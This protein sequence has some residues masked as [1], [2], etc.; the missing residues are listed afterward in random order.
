MPY[1]TCDIQTGLSAAQKADLAEEI[2]RIT[3]EHIGSPI[4]YIHVAVR[5]TPAAHF[6]EGGKLNRVYGEAVANQ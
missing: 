6:V 2:V 5:E 1:I 3:H 4:P